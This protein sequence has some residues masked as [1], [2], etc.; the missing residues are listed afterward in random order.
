MARTGLAV[1]L[2]PQGLLPIEVQEITAV[3]KEVAET[4]QRDARREALTTVERIEARATAREV[5]ITATLAG[6]LEVQGILDLLEVLA[7]AAQDLLVIHLQVEA[8][9]VAAKE[10]KSIIISTLKY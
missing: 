7:A 3:L 9:E 8:T 1:G 4:I 5:L 10:I 6:L 2:R